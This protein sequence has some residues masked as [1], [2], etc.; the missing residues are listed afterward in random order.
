MN[1]APDSINKSSK[2]VT[3]SQFEV[4]TLPVVCRRLLH[5]NRYHQLLEYH[6]QQVQ[7][8]HQE[9]LYNE[10]FRSGR[11]YYN[12]FVE[13]AG[14]LGYHY[15]ELSEKVKDPKNRGSA[16]LAYFETYCLVIKST[17]PHLGINTFSRDYYL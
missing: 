11:V 12:I 15:E 10:P 17:N 14:S 3:S 5:Q 7:L 8:S 1:S 2:S 9:G 13:S 16:S 6:P 4:H